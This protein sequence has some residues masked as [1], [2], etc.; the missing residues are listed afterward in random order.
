MIQNRSLG[1]GLAT[2]LLACIATALVDKATVITIIG[3]ISRSLTIHGLVLDLLQ[4]RIKILVSNAKCRKCT[5]GRRFA[6]LQNGKHQVF[7]ANVLVPFFLRDLCCIK[8]SRLATCRKIEDCPMRHADG[9]NATVTRQ[10]ALHRFTE[11]VQIDL[12]R[13]QGLGRK[14]GIFTDKPQQQVFSRY[15]VTTQVAGRNTSRLQ[16]SLRLLRK[17]TV[18]I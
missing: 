6:L 2:N 13:H 15:A 12:K 16:N 9:H 17:N 7:R 18:D 8:K 14:S 3:T 10:R 1:T 4:G 11:F 5:R